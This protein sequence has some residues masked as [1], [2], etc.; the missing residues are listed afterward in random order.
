MGKTRQDKLH[1]EGRARN[2]DRKRKDRIR[3]Q[4]RT[5]LIV[6]EGSKTEPNY[7]EDL[8]KHLGIAARVEV[9]GKKCG[10]D[11][12]SVLRYAKKLKNDKNMP[13]YDHV[14][15][16]IDV[17]RYG[18]RTGEIT[19]VLNEARVASIKM[20]ISNPCFEVWVLFHFEE[21]GKPFD[22]CKDVIREVETH[23][24]KYTK[25]GNIYDNYLSERTQIAIENAKTIKNRNIS[26]V[27]IDR[28][29]YT[30]VYLIVENLM[31]LS[32]S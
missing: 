19:T 16:V 8:T 5:V 22:K 14:W 4:R 18:K 15:C 26:T 32:K 13:N 24:T 11:P 25:G 30:E 27:R 2:A 31:K 29:P 20:A 12:K 1:Q 21:Y 6:C 10:S 7:F 17:E 23:V 9:S 28:N 3:A